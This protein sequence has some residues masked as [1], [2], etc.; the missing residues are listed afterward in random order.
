[1]TAEFPPGKPVRLQTGNTQ[2][3]QAYFILTQGTYER[4][5]GKAGGREGGRDN[6]TE[7]RGGEGGMVSESIWAA[8][9]LQQVGG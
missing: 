1:M 2:L 8:K 4:G 3:A 5:G 9:L 7:R 6:E